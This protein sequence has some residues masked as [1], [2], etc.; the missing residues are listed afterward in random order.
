MENVNLRKVKRFLPLKM[1][2][3]V[4]SLLAEQNIGLVFYSS[5]NLKLDLNNFKFL[6]LLQRRCSFEIVFSETQSCTCFGV[7]VL[8]F[9]KL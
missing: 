5:S 7:F 1:T 3:R 6:L 2:V 4:A 9:M 8:K